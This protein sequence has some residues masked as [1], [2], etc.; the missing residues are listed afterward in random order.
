MLARLRC[1]T[2]CGIE[3]ATVSVEVDVTSGLPSFTTVG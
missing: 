1:A 3:A 2:L